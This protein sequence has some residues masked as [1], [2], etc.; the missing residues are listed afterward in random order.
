MRSVGL[1]DVLHEYVCGALGRAPYIRTPFRSLVTRP[2]EKCGLTAATLVALLAAAGCA[3]TRSAPKFAYS[4]ESFVLAVWARAPEMSAEDLVVPFRVSPAMVAR[5]KDITAGAPTDWVKAELLMQSLT[6]EDGFG[7]VYNAVATSPPEVTVERGYGNCLALTSIF[8]GL[9][10]EIGLTA[11]YVDA[12]DRVNDL[13]REQGIIVDSGHI[14]GAVRTEKGHT[15][16]DYDG[17]V[18]HYRTFK[19]IDD[20]TALAHYYNN[21]GFEMIFAAQQADETV[22]WQQIEH[23]FE[24]ATM[25]RPDFTLAYNNLGVVYTRLGDLDAAAAAYRTAIE[26]DPES[27]A[28][29]H[30]LGNLQMREGDLGAALASYDKA[31]ELRRRNPYLH[32]H[33]G[34]VQYRLDELDAAEESFK[35]A[36]ELERD[37]LEPRNLLAQLYYEQ[38]R[39]E[40]AEKVRAAVQRILA[41]RR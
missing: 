38:G 22:P 3:G 11:Y 8:I 4:P 13:R 36:I 18:S 37:Y 5:A 6:D 14:A 29:Y 2:V 28:A 24:L 21:L 34:L 35:K 15:L 16:V 25:V 27:D 7:L 20:I 23:K 26:T 41:E 12:S 31:L 1:L 30:N 19:I 17:Y 33:R 10:R 9:A 40:E 32:Y 39:V